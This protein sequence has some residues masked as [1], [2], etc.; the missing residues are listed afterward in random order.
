MKTTFLF[1]GSEEKYSMVKHESVGVTSKMY[2]HKIPHD[3]LEDIK[4]TVIPTFH[5]IPSRF[6]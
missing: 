6:V 4:K 1:D 5:D 3:M 2:S